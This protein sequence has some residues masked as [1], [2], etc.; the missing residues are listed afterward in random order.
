MIAKDFEHGQHWYE[1]EVDPAP[2]ALDVD[3]SATRRPE[4]KS[5]QDD[6]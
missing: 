3:H 4:L 1:I 2:L 5:W 6:K